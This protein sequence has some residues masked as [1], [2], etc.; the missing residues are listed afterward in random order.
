MFDRRLIQSFD[1]GLLAI[2][3][4]I[5]VI[6]MVVLYSAVS[7]GEASSQTSIFYKQMIWH[8]MGLLMMLI[9]F[10][11]SYKYLDKWAP[12][13]YVISILLL[14]CVH[15]FGKHAG[16]STRW[17]P[18][19]P[20]TLQPSEPVKI[21]IIIILARYFSKNIKVSGITF[22]GLIVPM[23]LTAIPFLLVATQPDLGTAGTILL[24]AASM[25]MFSKIDRRTF[26]CVL[27]IIIIIVPVGWKMLEPYQKERILT[28]VSP[29]RDPLGT[30]YHIR[31]SKI[32][33][34]SGMIFGKGYMQGTQKKLSFLPEQHTD[35]IFSVLAE[36]W[37][38]AGSMLVLFLFLLLIAFGLNIAHGCRD[39]FGTILS[40]GITV[41]IFWQVFINIA[42]VMGLMPVVGMPLPLISYGGS[43]VITSYIGVGILINISMRRFM[44]K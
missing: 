24:I 38:F 31:Q 19:G 39:S 44:N 37:G 34:G 36:E 28:L 20:F 7:V 3:I 26:I 35:F 4:I 12:V 15:L 13:I 18:I 11:F 22:R 5:G 1:W 30:G 8:S 6:G 43:S 16:G 42:M 21:A 25:A 17:L 29:D 23:I 10:I 32:A 33:V 2:T 9:T 27:L 41:M 40:V 14:I